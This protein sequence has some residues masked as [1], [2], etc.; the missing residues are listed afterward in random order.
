[1]RARC[2]PEIPIIEAL[3]HGRELGVIAGVVALAEM[4]LAG[5][6]G[7]RIAWEATG[8]EAAPPVQDLIRD[9]VEEVVARS[10]PDVIFHL[11]AESH[12]DRSTTASRRSI[13]RRA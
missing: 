2:V 5:G 4:A 6:L 1:M 11:A 12:V 10:S 13:A 9:A 8:P 7:A 3:G